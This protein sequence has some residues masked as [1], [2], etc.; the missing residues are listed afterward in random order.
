MKNIKLMLAGISLLLFCGCG[1]QMQKENETTSIKENKENTIVENMMSRRSIRKY[2]PQ[3]VGRD[4]MQVILNCGINAPNGQNKQSWEIRVVDNPE[5]INGITEVF[6][7]QNPKAAEDPNFLNMFRNAPTVVFIANDKS[8]DMSQIDCG[9]LGENMIL[10]AWSM[11]IGSC[12]LGS[13]ARF[14][15]STPEAAEYLKKL[16]I[17]EGYELLYCIAFGYPDETPEA[18]PRNAEKIRFID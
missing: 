5:F 4:T 7:K 18:K 6:K 17:P 8:Y 15:T 10:A 2:K 16:D 12:C 1:T 13:S 14:M 11:G 9:L 3:P